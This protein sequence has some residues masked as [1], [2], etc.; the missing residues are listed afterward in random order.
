MFY[1][2]S[3][4]SIPWALQMRNQIVFRLPLIVAIEIAAFIILH[5]QVDLFLIELKI[6]SV[7][8]PYA[9]NSSFIVRNLYRGFYFMGFSTGYYFLRTYLF[10]KR[11]AAD[12]QSEKL[13]AIIKQKTTE[14][15]LLKAQI[16]P[17]F[18]FNTL[19]FIYNKVSSSSPSAADAV[20]SLSEMM[21][22]A[23]TSDERGGT[24]QLEEEMEQVHNLFSLFKLRKSQPLY[25]KLEFAENTKHIPFIPLVLL[26]LA[27][28]MFKH[29][30]LHDPSHEATLK[31]YIENEFLYIESNNL[32]QPQK[33]DRS[34]TGLANISNRLAYAYGEQISF[35]HT[36]SANQYFTL[37]LGVPL[38]RLN[39]PTP[40]ATI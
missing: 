24:I 10:E 40:F 30:Q 15:A 25:L 6:V 9:F 12:L 7:K 18:L 5:Y 33:S 16:N 21:R 2:H 27:E 32:S 28:N 23:I 8:A 31:V 38:A 26:T 37:K 14:Q 20:L 39:E 36:T 19:N 17:H 11:R 22:Y 4:V 29:G 13:N 35:E 1:L 34:S 3:N